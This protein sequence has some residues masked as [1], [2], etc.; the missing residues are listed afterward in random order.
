MVS[1]LCAHEQTVTCVRVASSDR[2]V[3][4]SNDGTMRL[5]DIKTSSIQ[6]A[7]LHI[8]ASAFFEVRTMVAHI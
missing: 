7:S 1:E 8:F 5:W 6:F 3:S 4:C 2:I